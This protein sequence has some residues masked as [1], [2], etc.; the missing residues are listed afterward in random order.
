M[1]AFAMKQSPVHRSLTEELDGNR[2]ALC[3]RR[4]RNSTREDN[5]G[6]TTCQPVNCHLSWRVQSS[7]TTSPA[8]NLQGN[9]GRWR[10]MCRYSRN[11]RARFEHKQINHA[12]RDHPSGRNRPSR[13]GRTPPF[14]RCL[15]FQR[16]NLREVSFSHT[17]AGSGVSTMLQEPKSR[18][19]LSP[20]AGG[21]NIA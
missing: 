4:V 11:T 18:A 8:S 15:A 7:R 12:Q 19:S 14:L 5:Y 3:T 17:I 6:R 21:A 1:G 10:Q 13:K 2:S 16:F 9:C 20:G